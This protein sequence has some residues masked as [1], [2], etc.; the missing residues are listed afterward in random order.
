MIR[1]VFWTKWYWWKYYTCCVTPFSFPSYH[2]WGNLVILQKVHLLVHFRINIS[3]HISTLH[4]TITGSLIDTRYWKFAISDTLEK[5]SRHVVSQKREIFPCVRFLRFNM[6]RTFF[7]CM[8]K[9]RRFFYVIWLLYQSVLYV[10]P[11][12]LRKEIYV[13]YI[14]HWMKELDLL[15]LTNNYLKSRELL[16]SIF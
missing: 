3:V 9:I 8:L 16:K 11:V 10:I 13:A 6:S 7:E 5:G 14:L 4:S 15:L 12:L 1:F 2:I